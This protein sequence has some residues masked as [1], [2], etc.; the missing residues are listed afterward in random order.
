MTSKTAKRS[1]K[2]ITAMH[3]QFNKTQPH[4]LA[5]FFS[6]FFSMFKHKLKIKPEPVI[7]KHQ[8]KRSETSY[9]INCQ[10]LKYW[11]SFVER[12]HEIFTKA[13]ILIECQIYYM[14]VA[15]ALWFFQN[16]FSILQRMIT[17]LVAQRTSSPV[18]KKSKSAS[19]SSEETVAKPLWK[20]K[21]VRK[22]QVGGRPCS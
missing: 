19:S 11:G 3:W 5:D 18:L 7:L 15:C 4:S 6:C 8:N 22:R 9:N 14:Y 20:D 16:Q 13:E 17:T 1:Y 10:T 21:R 2:R 12:D